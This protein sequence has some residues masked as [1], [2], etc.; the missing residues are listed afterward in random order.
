TVNDGSEPFS[1]SSLA[2]G[3]SVKIRV[4]AIDNVFYAV[5]NATVSASAS[6]CTTSTDNGTTWTV[7]SPSTVNDGSEPFSFSS[8]ATGASVK[9][10]V[11]AIDNVFY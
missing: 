5:G 4:S 3:A 11:S 2:T 9:I 8:L 7:I 10:R 6:A 1:F